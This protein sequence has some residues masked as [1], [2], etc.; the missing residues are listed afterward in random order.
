MNFLRNPN[1]IFCNKLSMIPVMAIKTTIDLVDPL[2]RLKSVDAKIFSDFKNLRIKD[3][4]KPTDIPKIGAP[5]HPLKAI[6]AYPCF[7]REQFTIKS[8][9]E[10]PTDKIV[11]AR[12]DSFI[13]KGNNN[14]ASSIIWIK[15]L[16]AT[17]THN[18]DIIKEEINNSHSHF[19][20][21]VL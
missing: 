6:S 7:A 18:N 13:S 2:A 16:L 21:F 20:K 5:T 12:K 14:L 11:I 8:G 10:L 3:N 15:I 19:G 17:I 4:P 9:T 1:I